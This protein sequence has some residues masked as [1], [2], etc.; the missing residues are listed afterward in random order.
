MRKEMTAAII[1]LAIVLPVTAYYLVFNYVGGTGIHYNVG[2]GIEFNTHATPVWIAL[3]DGLFSQ[4]GINVT[5]VLKFRT[6]LELAAAMARGDVKAGWA[7]LGPA[8]LIIDKGIPV[9]IVAKVHNYGYELVVNPDKI[10]SVSDLNGAV[11]YAPG[12]GSP[13]Y[14]LLLKIE[15]TYNISF[16]E[17][18]FMKP[19][20]ILSALLSGQIYAA[21]L[22]EHYA[23]VAASKGM[24][25][26]V[27]SQE[28][29][30]NMPGS[31]LVV[32]EELIENSPD[33][34][35]ELIKVTYDGIS[36]I[37]ADP[38]AAA[39][40]DSEMLGISPDVAKQSINMLE[41][42]TTIDLN[43]I[44]EYIDFMYSHG[45]LHNHLNASEIV[46]NIGP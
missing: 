34:V 26:L 9:K 7:C 4:H 35:K 31:F 8:L 5:D 17:I 22:P 38:E 29:W 20:N 13:C 1:T 37:H 10:R 24:K 15:D 27:R 42:D 3:H 12:K 21:A 6:G 28:V 30:P 45:L 19:S 2:L 11:V 46:V 40:I 39:E 36:K 25:I 16:K 32:D 18:K 43:Q 41:W 23:S 33:L 44:Q 14:L